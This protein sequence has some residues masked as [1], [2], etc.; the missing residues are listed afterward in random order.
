MLMTTRQPMNSDNFLLH[1]MVYVS[2]L[3]RVKSLSVVPIVW[4]CLNGV[5]GRVPWFFILP[6]V[7]V[8]GVYLRTEWRT[9]GGS[10]LKNLGGGRGKE[11]SERRE[12][13]WRGN[14]KGEGTGRGR[15][16][17]QIEIKKK[18]MYLPSL[19]QWHLY[20]CTHM[21]LIHNVCTQ[22]YQHCLVQYM[23]MYMY[24]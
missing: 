9:R 20:H 3:C 12:G 22:C 14:K 21:T 7:T 17:S 10:G 16:R 5:C 8:S 23:F 24:L 4:W 2:S 1:E 18:S 11:G 13:R 19:S 15:E 6:W